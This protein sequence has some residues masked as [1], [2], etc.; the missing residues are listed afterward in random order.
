MLLFCP[1]PLGL[2]LLLES[3]VS[4]HGAIGVLRFVPFAGIEVRRIVLSQFSMPDKSYSRTAAAWTA[5]RIGSPVN[6][7][8]S[9]SWRDWVVSGD[10]R[11]SLGDANQ[12]DD[13]QS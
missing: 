1:I 5:V 7:C 2:N 9:L 6:R 3:R 4:P 8:I 10:G 11:H 12:A 13:A